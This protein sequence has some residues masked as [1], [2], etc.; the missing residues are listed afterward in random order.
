MT[1]GSPVEMF[2]A[3]QAFKPQYERQFEG[4]GLL[5]HAWLQ[6]L[7]A[8][9]PVDALIETLSLA[10]ARPEPWFLGSKSR[11]LI[12][13]SCFGLTHLSTQIGKMNSS[14]EILAIG[15]AMSEA[16]QCRSKGTGPFMNR[17]GAGLHQQLLIQ[18]LEVHKISHA[19]ASSSLSDQM[20]IAFINWSMTH[21]STELEVAGLLCNCKNTFWFPAV[22]ESNPNMFGLRANP[23]VQG[24]K[25]VASI[26]FS[27]LTQLNIH[28]ALAIERSFNKCVYS[29]L[30]R[31]LAYLCSL[32]QILASR[33]FLSDPVKITS[34]FDSNNFERAG[35]EGIEPHHGAIAAPFWRV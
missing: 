12:G 28:A 9:L 14:N 2:C 24:N 33:K 29:H 25:C 6:S 30:R 16:A 5:L 26:A 32:G 15:H 34:G 11:L 17:F 8:N 3:I 27:A 22:H 35:V 23:G 7:I 10:L 20:E 21:S 13:F 18:V 4:V 1:G 19:S 31:G